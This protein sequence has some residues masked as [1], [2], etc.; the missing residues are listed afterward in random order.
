MTMHNN[1]GSRRSEEDRQACEAVGRT[2]RADL[3]RDAKAA[4]RSVRLL[5]LVGVVL[6]AVFLWLGVWGER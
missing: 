5:V 1:G 6:A 3:E 4:R 2:T